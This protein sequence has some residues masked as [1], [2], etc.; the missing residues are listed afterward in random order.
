MRKALLSFTAFFLIGATALA[1]QPTTSQ[2]DKTEKPKNEVERAH[3]EAVARGETVLGICIQNCE[4]FDKEVKPGRVI[5]LPK[6]TYS[7]LA[8]AAH[9]SGTVEVQVL[10]GLDGSVI[11]AAAI[12]GHPLL[13]ASAVSAARDTR[14]TPTTVGGKPVKVIGVVHYNFVDP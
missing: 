12:S 5:V 8:R 4:V 9:V 7:P 2:A 3:E 6:P 10:I 14:F 11:A 1:Q 13:L